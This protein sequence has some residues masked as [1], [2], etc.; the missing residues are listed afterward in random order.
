[1]NKNKVFLIIRDGWGYS[2]EEKGNAITAAKTPFDDYINSAYKP[3]ILKAH[4]PSVGLPEGFQ[5]S[6]E[7]GHM[8]MGAGQIVTQ[9][10][11]RIND[12]LETGDF[13]KSTKFEESLSKVEKGKT[14]IHL[15]G[16]LQD[17]G[18]HAHQQH[19]FL[20]L[21]YF[22]NNFPENKIYVHVFA[23]GR[24]TPPKS[25][26]T[27]LKD[28]EQQLENHENGILAT[29]AGRYY[30]MDRSKNYKL[31]SIGFDAI[32]SAKGERFNDIY[33]K[34]HECYENQKTPDNQPMF[35][36]YLK[37]LINSDYKGVNEGDIL[38]NFNYRQDR[39]IQITRAFTEPDSPVNSDFI[40]N[41][42]TIWL[43]LDFI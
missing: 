7:V 10:V 6:S 27:F 39:A 11:T 19:L 18:V 5:G 9:E 26:M 3:V 12:L 2:N 23:D 20:L 41:C 37:P 42:V 29:V 43:R 38:I 32:C 33:G 17:E 35:D 25:T 34:I 22:F 1:M 13:Y 21:Q 14:A 36:E 28:L 4:G 30:S 15:M 8:N 31:I 16:L 24:D 40:N